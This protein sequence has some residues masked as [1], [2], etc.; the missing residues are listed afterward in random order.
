M[1]EQIFP[2]PTVGALIFNSEGKLFLMKSHK[3]H[4]AYVIPG[5][6]IELGETAEDALRREIK[7]ETALDI[8]DVEFLCVQE[9]IN[10][11]AFWKMRHFIFLDYACKTDA[12]DVVLNSEGHDHIWVTLDEAKDLNIDSYTRNVISRYLEKRGKKPSGRP[13]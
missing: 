7:E 13:W 8:Y 9:F 1:A 12:T 10:D 11:P 5:G 3:W 4:D 6:H 2:E